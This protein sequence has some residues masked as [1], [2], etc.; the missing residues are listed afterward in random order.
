[1]DP[2]FN[3]QC[4]EDYRKDSLLYKA[5]SAAIWAN[6]GWK[7]IQQEGFHSACMDGGGRFYFTMLG[8]TYLRAD[9]GVCVPPS[10]TEDDITWRVFPLIFRQYFDFGEQ[11]DLQFAVHYLPYEP[12]SWAFID[13][14]PGEVFWSLVALA[15]LAVVG[16]RP[17]SCAETSEGTGAA[18]VALWLLVVAVAA[19]E[20]M[21]YTRWN[22]YDW[23]QRNWAPFEAVAGIG[24]FALEAFLAFPLLCLMRRAAAESRLGQAWHSPGPCLRRLR[25][26]AAA[27]LAFGVL[28]RGASRLTVNRFSSGRWIEGWLHCMNSCAEPDLQVFLS[29]ADRC[30]F[31]AT[32]RASALRAALAAPCALLATLSPAVAVSLSFV[33]AA[34]CQD[35]DAD[36]RRALLSVASAAFAAFAAD[37]PKR[38]LKVAAFLVLGTA[39]ALVGARHEFWDQLPLALTA[40]VVPLLASLLPGSG[41]SS[42]TAMDLALPAMPLVLYV[43]EGYVEPH[44]KDLTGSDFLA[45]CLGL[46]SYSFATAA[47]VSA[48]VLGLW[49][50]P[51]LPGELWALMQLPT[52]LADA[53]AAL[54][55]ERAK[56]SLW[57][58][59]DSDVRG[60]QTN[61]RGSGLWALLLLEAAV[62]I[63]CPPML[64][65][66]AA[67]CDGLDGHA[68]TSGKKNEVGR[69]LSDPSQAA[70]AE[71]D[72]ARRLQQSNQKE[73]SLASSG[74]AE[75]VDD[76]DDEVTVVGSKSYLDDL[77]AEELQERLAVTSAQ[78]KE[79]LLE[80]WTESHA[81]DAEGASHLVAFWRLSCRLGTAA[82]DTVAAEISLERASL[83]EKGD[84]V[85]FGVA[86]AIV[87]YAWA[88]QGFRSSDFDA[89]IFQ[90]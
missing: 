62:A 52:R 53:E 63:R 15:A 30:R 77:S 4:L 39:A 54:A 13:G 29:G 64:I 76:D 43:V 18:R 50:V 73:A 22:M 59:S 88:D 86:P 9:L 61:T 23:F 79:S 34:A 60:R 82:S 74:V 10:C 6:G 46:L 35:F 19:R 66:A 5:H 11:H 69:A 7:V 21:L 3:P 40:L 57:P 67:V 20:V 55:E 38:W 70:K 56:W 48:A 78:L 44:A 90:R 71:R 25:D 72:F 58:S 49:Q 27:A 31:F 36:V 2:R 47:A 80:E 14:L 28:T 16:C 26:L 83:F 84:L 68:K 75:A 24:T 33:A 81:H 85:N 51:C 1:M 32:L 45:R 37:A 87:M 8:S 41:G 17:S 12:L 65:I 42:L 89:L